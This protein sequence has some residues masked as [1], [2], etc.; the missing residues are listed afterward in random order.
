M[1]RGVSLV[2]TCAGGARWQPRRVFAR[3][4]GGPARGS[5]RLVVQPG[6]LP[7]WSRSITAVKNNSLL[8][9]QIKPLRD[10]SEASSDYTFG[11]TNQIVYRTS[12]LC[13]FQMAVMLRWSLSEGAHTSN[14][15]GRE[16]GTSFPCLWPCYCLF[17]CTI[18]PYAGLQTE[19]KAAHLQKHSRRV[20][21]SEA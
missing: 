14:A 19:Y 13:F 16:C 10:A 11:Q 15:V 8:K 9:A 3:S 1:Q 4:G 20:T 12:N 21:V 2:C 18:C 17:R 6:D 5:W 7:K